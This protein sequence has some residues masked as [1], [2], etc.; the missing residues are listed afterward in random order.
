MLRNRTTQLLLYT[1]INSDLVK[2]L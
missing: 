1:K 2:I